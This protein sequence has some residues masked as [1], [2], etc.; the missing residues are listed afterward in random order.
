MPRT[1]AKPAEPA[2]PVEI[3]ET[4]QAEV[5]LAGDL[6][7]GAE[8]IGRA[9]GRPTR[10]IYHLHATRRLPTF[11][12]G[13][14]LAARKSTLIRYVLDLERAGPREKPKR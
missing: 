1:Q 8:E 4:Y 13:S 5:E 12:W 14:K 9:I 3:A 2:E 10:E 6:V 11:S 7:V